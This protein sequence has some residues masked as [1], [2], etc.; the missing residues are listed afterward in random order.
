MDCVKC[1]ATL[2]EGAIFCPLCGKKQ[3]P[4]K[5][6]RRKRANGSGSI[7]KLKGNRAKPWAAQKNGVLVGCFPTYAAAQK[8]LER[9]TDVDVTDKYNLTFHQVYDLWRPSHAR[10]VSKTQM[11]CY[12]SAYKN[13][14]SL[15]E[16]KF[17]TLRKSDFEAV[18]LSLEEAGKSKSTCEKVL[19]LFGQLSKW[20]I[21]EGIVNQNHAKNVTTTAQQKGTQVSF[22]EDQIRAI[23]NATS[24]AKTIALVLIATGARTIELFNVPLTD[25]YDNYFIAG[26]KQKKGQPVTKRVI[27][28]SEVGLDAY[29]EMLKEAR[30]SGGTRLIDGYEG[31]RDSA[32]FRKRDFSELME[33]IGCPGITPYA[34]RHTFSTRAVRAGVNPQYLSRMMGHT[35]IKTADKHYVHLDADDILTE[36]AKITTVA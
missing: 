22:S 27:A 7:Y 13:S 23:Q 19:Q 8:A 12:A 17:R 24:R 33:E 29:R 26:S 25:C 10:E 14:A 11:D 9:I 16:Q 36:I 21:D 3:T 6:K 15:H 4:E 5:K 2:P 34:C 32:N 28:V 30:E 1:K 20:A 35:D 18:I 31:N